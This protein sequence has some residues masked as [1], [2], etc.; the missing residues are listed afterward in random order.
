MIAGSSLN[1]KQYHPKTIPK[2]LDIWEEKKTECS[3][4]FNLRLRHRNTNY[5]LAKKGAGNKMRLMVET[6]T[7]F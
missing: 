4:D 1:H 6:K 7:S 5:H 3:K 2:K